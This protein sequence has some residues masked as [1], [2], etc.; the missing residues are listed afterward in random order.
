[1]NA[2]HEWIDPLLSQEN[3]IQPEEADKPNKSGPHPVANPP[4]KRIKS[5]AL[6]PPPGLFRTTA[7]PAPFARPNPLTPA[8]PET[9]FLPVFNREAAKRRVTVEYLWEFSGQSHAGRWT[10]KCIG[11]FGFSFNEQQYDICKVNGICK[12]EGSSSNKQTAKEEAAR[13]AFDNMGWR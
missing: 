7:P 3:L 13:N 9:A 8:Q 10:A 12:G 1:L 11:K 5:E 4:P 6:S 2:L